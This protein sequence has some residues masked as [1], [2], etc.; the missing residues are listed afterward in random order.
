MPQKWTPKSCIYHIHKFMFL[1]LFV[2]FYSTYTYFLFLQN[3]SRVPS[4]QLNTVVL[5]LTFYTLQLQYSGRF[6]CTVTGRH[7]SHI[8]KKTVELFVFPPG[9]KIGK[10]IQTAK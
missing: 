5:N 10:K 8:V 6:V 4:T 7:P 2:R 9:K 3:T 1:L